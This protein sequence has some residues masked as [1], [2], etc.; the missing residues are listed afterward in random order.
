MPSDLHSDS[1]NS[2]ENL[3]SMSDIISVGNPWSFHI[4]RRK[5]S[6]TSLAVAFSLSAIKCAILVNRSTTTII[7]VC[8]CDSGRWVMK[9]VE[10]DVHAAK[11]VCSGCNSPYRAC[12]G[13]LLCWHSSQD[14]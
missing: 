1:Q 9:S 8:P 2:P 4:S 13:D 5:V 3:A 11:G 6:A 10:I 7:W 12:L 14:L